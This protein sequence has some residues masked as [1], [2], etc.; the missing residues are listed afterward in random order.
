MSE[1]IPVS[2]T[3]AEAE[4]IIG[5]L[6]QEWA[7]LDPAGVSGPL[8]DK[9]QALVDLEQDLIAM[10]T[11]HSVEAYGQSS[12]DGWFCRNCPSGAGMWQLPPNYTHRGAEE[13]HLVWIKGRGWKR[14]AA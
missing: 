13:A 1:L 5:C 6:D 12:F 2:L 11:T 4:M 14:A 7:G 3:L 8:Q 10:R 9:L